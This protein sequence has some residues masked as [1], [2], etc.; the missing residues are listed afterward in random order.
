MSDHINPKDLRIPLGQQVSCRFEIEDEQVYLYVE[1]GYIRISFL[2]P[3]AYAMW[4]ENKPLGNE[5]CPDAASLA[6]F[7]RKVWLGHK[8][9]ARL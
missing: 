5:I 6:K 2:N 3:M 4:G 8:Y 9:G 1:G 7:A